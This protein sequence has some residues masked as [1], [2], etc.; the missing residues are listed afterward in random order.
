MY[1][2]QLARCHINNN[3]VLVDVL[4]IVD[5]IALFTSLYLHLLHKYNVRTIE[6]M[7]LL[8]M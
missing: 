2:M 5:T 8:V 6:L 4:R 1:T 7:L 3:N